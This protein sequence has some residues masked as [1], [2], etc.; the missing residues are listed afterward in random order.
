MK[1]VEQGI[2][3]RDFR[4]SLRILEQEV[5]LSMASET[6]CCGVTLAQCHILL[7][8][9]Q[10]G[11][12]S[13]TEL[14]ALL[15][16]DKSTM[17]RTVDTMCRAGLL[18]RETDPSNRRQQIISLT[19]EGRLKSDRIN[20][21]CDTSYTRLFDFIPADKRRMVVESAALLAHAMRQRRKDPAS[22]CCTDDGSKGES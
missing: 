16:L 12:T 11:R 2:S 22:A 9:D 10:R 17:S 20:D 14:A 4:K 7:E 21:L 8:V 18:N 15:E 1:M 6:G 19:E 5:D 13:V 3:I